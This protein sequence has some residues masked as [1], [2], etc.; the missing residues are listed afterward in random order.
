M[1]R[2]DYQLIADVFKCY[3]LDCFPENRPTVN[4]LARNMAI[5]LA[6][7]NPKFDKTHFLTTCGLM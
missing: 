5:K 2:K 7:D 1:T 4:A 6:A 3:S